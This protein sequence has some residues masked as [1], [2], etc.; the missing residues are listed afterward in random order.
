[1]TDA[2]NL[3]QYSTAVTDQTTLIATKKAAMEAAE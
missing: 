2:A 3:E 1:V